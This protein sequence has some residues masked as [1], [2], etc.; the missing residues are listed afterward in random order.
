MDKNLKTLVAVLTV[1][2]LI[3][4]CVAMLNPF[5]PREDKPAVTIEEAE[6]LSVDY[7]NLAEFHIV[8]TGNCPITVTDANGKELV[9]F[10]YT[11]GTDDYSVWLTGAYPISVTVADV[12]AVNN[13]QSTIIL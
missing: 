12:Y 8:C 5:M 1:S 2:A 11:V 7:W 9:T 10:Q 13:G 6:C 4:V 3:I